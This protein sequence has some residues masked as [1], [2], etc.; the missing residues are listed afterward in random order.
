MSGKKDYFQKQY[1][2]YKD[3]RRVKIYITEKAQSQILVAH[4]LVGDIEWSGFHFFK[5]IGGNINE[6]DK[7]ELE[8]RHIHILDVGTPG[9]TEFTPNER[10]MEVYDDYPEATECKMGIIHTH[11]NMSTFFSGTD[12]KELH[13]NVDKYPYY[14]SLIV[15]HKGIYTARLVYLVEEEREPTVKYN[16]R[17]EKLKNRR[18]KLPRNDSSQ[19]MVIHE[20]DVLFYTDGYFLDR[21][22]ELK[23]ARKRI[24]AASTYEYDYSKYNYSNKNNYTGGSYDN[25]DAN[26]NSSTGKQVDFLQE[27]TGLTD[28]AKELNAKSKENPPRDI[29]FTKDNINKFMVRI[30]TL[31]PLSTETYPF[32]AMKKLVYSRDWDTNCSFYYDKIDETF[33]KMFIEYFG[34]LNSIQAQR[35]IDKM[36]VQLNVY[37]S[38]PKVNPFISFLKNMCKQKNAELY[39]PINLE[40]ERTIYVD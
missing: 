19:I 13:D 25:A 3:P 27:L 1:R 22:S 4:A 32:S 31:D 23:E 10:M 16:S 12:E 29:D 5:E 38:E 37:M 6:P 39:N 20:C 36:I 26:T 14:V 2:E 35:V 40:K 30:I 9:Y 8:L 18:M 15:N 34:N 33:W 21:L 28:F 17:L 11:H 24:P 7:L